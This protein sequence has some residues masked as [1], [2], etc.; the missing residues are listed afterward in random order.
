M[1]SSVDTLS[2]IGSFQD[3]FKINNLD[4]VSSFLSAADKTE[5]GLY[6]IGNI[7]N[8]SKQYGV[9]NVLN[10]LDTVNDGL[11]FIVQADKAIDKVK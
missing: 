2:G 3:V 8:I 4:T 10:K 7:E 5:K 9:K 11:N 1:Y 6:G